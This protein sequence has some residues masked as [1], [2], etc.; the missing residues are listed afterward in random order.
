M[1]VTMEDRVIGPAIPSHL[2]SKRNK[3]QKEEEQDNDLLSSNKK[4]RNDEGNEPA[5]LEQSDVHN[6]PEMG[7]LYGPALPDTLNQCREVSSYG[8]ALP[9]DMMESSRPETTQGGIKNVIIIG[10]DTKI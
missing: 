2:L 5:D 1:N 8:P 4:P 7:S 10:V 9:P 6:K 3:T